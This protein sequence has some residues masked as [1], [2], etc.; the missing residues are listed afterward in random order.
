MSFSSNSMSG[1][2]LESVV[3]IPSLVHLDMSSNQ[4]NGT[5]PKFLY[6]MKGLKYLNLENNNFQGAVPFNWSSIKMFVVFKASGTCNLCYN[7]S[8][9]SFK[10]KIGIT[11]VIKMGSQF[12]QPD[13]S[14][15]SS[16]D[17]SSRGGGSSYG[18]TT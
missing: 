2:I 11:H 10:L 5:L 3:A 9:V 14:S 4:F 6:E 1:P 12:F 8:I 18:S 7:R 15:S 16:Y 13:K 17:S